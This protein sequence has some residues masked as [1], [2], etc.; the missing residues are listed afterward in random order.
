MNLTG[1]WA[2][3]R[4]SIAEFLAARD[5]R[6]IRALAVA[7]FAGTSGLI[8]LLLVEPALTG[9][10][11]LSIDLPVLRGQ[12]EQMQLLAKE[13]AE[14]S[15]KPAATLSV[16]SKESIEADLARNG[17]KAQSVMLTGEYAKVQ[18]AAVSFGSTLNWL[19][20]WQKSA[21]VSVVDANIVALP[22]ADTVNATFTLQQSKNE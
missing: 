7:A 3:S 19:D 22:Q 10:D 1:L 16:M 4:V 13:T 5:A 17:L 6:E 18:L 8:Y 15:V 9:R 12:V 11:Q 2:Q 20:E 21:R 14:L